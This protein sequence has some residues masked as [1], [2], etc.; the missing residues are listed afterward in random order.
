MIRWALSS[1]LNIFWLSNLMFE[2]RWQSPRNEGSYTKDV[3]LFQCCETIRIRVDRY[4]WFN[5]ATYKKKF[6][7]G[8]SL[9]TF[10]AQGFSS[11]TVWKKEIYKKPKNVWLRT[12][13][14]AYNSKI[15][16]FFQSIMRPSS[17]D[18]LPKWC[19]VH[20]VRWWKNS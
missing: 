5:A 19:A 16:S 7:L 10:R 20:T 1:H 8:Y 6:L 14:I 2:N 9:A 13:R 11:L 4:F 17:P 18:T 12:I 3:T 15:L